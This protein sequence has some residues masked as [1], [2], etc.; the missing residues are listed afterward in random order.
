MKIS[1][2][3]TLSYIAVFLISLVGFSNIAIC[4]T[5][6][7]Q[8]TKTSTIKANELQTN[9][10][11]NSISAHGN[12]T[13]VNGARIFYADEIK[14]YRSEGE[15]EAEGKV[16]M[17]DEQENAIIA[18]KAKIK[19]DASKGEFYDALILFPNGSF[20]YSPHITKQSPTFSKL[21]KPKYGVCPSDTTFD[22]SY[23]EI[24]DETLG[25]RQFLSLNASTVEVNNEKEGVFF[26]NAV[27]KSYGVPFFYFPYL[28]T[29]QP[30]GKKTTG[31]EAPKLRKNSNYG[32]G[33]LLPYY[34]K[35]SESQNMRLTPTFYQEENQVLELEY[36]KNFVSRNGYFK[37]DGE[38]ANDNG[39]SDTI[40]DSNG[41]TR[42]QNG[43]EDEVRGY[44][45]IDGALELSK[46]WDTHFYGIA[47]G[48]KFYLQDYKNDYSDFLRSYG[49]IERLSENNI[50]SF[51]TLNFRELRDR[52]DLNVENTPDAIPIF[53]WKLKKHFLTFNTNVTSIIRGDGLQYNRGTVNPG[54]EVPYKFYGNL[55]K[56]ST[57]FRSDVY[58]L[59]ENYENERKDLY[60]NEKTR[61]IPQAKLDWE[62]PI[63]KYNKNSAFVVTPK[64]NF[65]ISKDHNDD[66][67]DIPN[68]DSVASE[69]NDVNLFS[70][71]RNSGYDRIESGPRI[72]YGIDTN[73]MHNYFGD[74]NAFIGQGY[75]TNDESNTNIRGFRENV[76]G[77]VG[78]VSYKTDEKFDIYYRFLLGRENFNELTNETE[79]NFHIKK[80]TLTANYTM[81]DP[82]VIDDTKIKQASLGATI[83]I[84]KKW[85]FL[86]SV[87]RDLIA[88]RT[89]NKSYE[90][91]YDGSCV[92]YSLSVK[93]YRPVDQTAVSRNIDFS[94]NVKANLF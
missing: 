61:F 17:K 18:E 19:D 79:A 59:D 75:R 35:I 55:F 5:E 6:E 44:G 8:Q 51:T 54:I 46:T 65:I 47:V 67:N 50:F 48:D 30:F 33:I 15:I 11:E 37:F 7:K 90:L 16:K 38:I 45:L 76:S 53:D 82:E 86:S 10:K 12:V 29:S 31:F 87:T 20:V 60:H 78:R 94:F 64:A 1:N 41:K 2:F 62:L 13:L 43:Y 92:I 49:T 40:E 88:D 14:Y 93:E 69:L 73:L 63:I 70:D 68:E 66:E 36:N 32:Y 74:F 22:K 80:L 21:L 34:I 42:K 25:K 23:E 71:N 9:K 72:N 58:A 84:T 26:Y 91:K 85:K 89:T 24:V 39:A 52:T 3:H 4:K 56:L 28:K 83:D 81:I 27:A 77:W 57:N